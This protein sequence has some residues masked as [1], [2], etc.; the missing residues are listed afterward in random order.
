M[1]PDQLK[2]LQ[3]LRKV[4]ENG[5]A[6]PSDIKELSELLTLIN[7]REDKEPFEGTQLNILK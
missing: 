5:I 1:S 6:S 3:E 7:F 4:F 2:K